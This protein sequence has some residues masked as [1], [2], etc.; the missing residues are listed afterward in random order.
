LAVVREQGDA[1]TRRHED[2][3]AVDNEGRPQQF[4]NPPRRGGGFERAVQIGCENQ[5]LVAAE[6][7]DDV[8]LAHAVIDTGGDLGDE[9]VAGR[10]SAGIVDLLE[11][12]EVQH[13]HRDHG[14][15]S[16]G[17]GKFVLGV[18][19]EQV[20]VRQTSQL[21]EIRQRLHFGEQD[22]PL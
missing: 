22:L 20:P 19:D 16:L 5:E 3:A 4:K 2:I 7:T 15:V 12:I 21:V 18:L 8:A 11:P 14:P 13:Q 9:G 6:P 17:A 10:M 1:D